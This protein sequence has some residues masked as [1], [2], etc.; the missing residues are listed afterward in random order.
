MIAPELIGGKPVLIVLEPSGEMGVWSRQVELIVDGGV[1]YSKN[2][3]EDRLEDRRQFEET[4]KAYGGRAAYD[5]AKSEGKT[6][7]NYQQW[8][9]VRTPAFKNWFGD[10]EN[11]GRERIDK[12]R[13]VRRAQA[14]Y[15]Q[16]AAADT[17]EAGG[18]EDRNRVGTVL[19]GAGTLMDLETG[20]PRVFYHGTSEDIKAFNLN[21]PTRKDSGWLGRGVYVAADVRMA[22]TY[23]NTK[24]GSAAPNVMPVFIRSTSGLYQATLS[25]KQVGSGLSQE[26]IDKATEALKQRGYDGAYLEFQSDSTIE[27][28][29]Y[30]VNNVKS[31]SG[32][33]GTFSAATDD[34]SFSRSANPASISA[35]PN[36]MAAWDSPSASKFDDFVYK[37]QDKHV[38]TKR[39]IEAI[40]DTGKAISDDLDVYLQETLFHGRAAKRTQDFLNKE[41]NPLIEYMQSAKVEMSDLEEFLHARHAQESSIGH[42]EGQIVGA[43]GIA[44]VFN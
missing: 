34:I 4:E 21:H 25:D 2:A 12:A 15:K 6:K 19:Y 18:R 7:L 36:G 14:G 28:V 35:A 44:W 26:N 20:E 11:A 39:V 42:K 5:Q 31:A 10:W 17:R 41:V 38:D 1:Q 24:N 43:G 32:N 30:S 23:A 27:L 8:V 9:Q 3:T 37:M 29:T 40:R 16:E 22:N 33:A 13:H